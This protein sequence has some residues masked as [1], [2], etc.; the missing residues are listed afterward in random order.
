VLLFEG[1]A[2]A[3]TGFI[4]GTGVLQGSLQGGTIWG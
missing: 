4:F 3:Q 2:E 1:H